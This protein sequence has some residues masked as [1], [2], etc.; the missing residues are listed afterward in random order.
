MVQ[1]CFRTQKLKE[2]FLDRDDDDLTLLH[3]LA[4]KFDANSVRNI[5]EFVSK[6]LSLEDQRELLLLE[7]KENLISLQMTFGNANSEIIEIFWKVY[8][9]IFD[10]EKLKSIISSENF[11][12][13]DHDER[14]KKVLSV[15]HKK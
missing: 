15:F 1:K 9:E 14:A 4:Y 2:V 8:C 5:F 13:Q 11:F 12:I 10:E 3:Q 6:S 7:Y